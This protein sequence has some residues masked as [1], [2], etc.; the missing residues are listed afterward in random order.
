MTR[1]LWLLLCVAVISSCKET[2]TK[3][4]LNNTKPIAEVFTEFYEF[5]KS[6]NPIEATKAG[7]SAYN[8]TI[9]NYIS[10]DYILHLKDR[11]SYFL[12]AL[13]AYDSAQVSSADYM[14]MR[15]MEW[16]CKVKL[17]GIMNP[18]VTVASPI[19]DLPSFELMPLFQIQSLH[20]YVAQLGGGTSVQP[21]KSIEDYNN[22]LKRLEDYLTFLDTS[23][24]KMRVGM[25]KGIVL[26]KELTLKMLPQV[27]SFIDIPLEENLFYQPIINFPDG[28]SDVD[29]DILKSNYEDFIQNNLTP[30]YVE[31]NE[32]LTEEYLPASRDTD[33]LLDLPNG[34]DTY[35]YLIKLHTTTNMTAD[36][37]HELGLAE[38]ARISKEME[39][40]KNEIGFKGDLKSFFSSLRNKKELMPFSNPE[41]VIESFNAINKRIALRIDSLFALTPKAGFNVRRTEAFREASASAEYVPGSKDGSRAGIFYVP[42]P[43]VKSYNMVHDEALFLHEAIPGHH[44][45][46]SLQQE[47][48]NLPEFLHPESMGV[49]VEGWALYAESLGK[50]LGIYTDPYQYFGMLS[51]EMHRAIRLVVDTGIHAKGWSR[52]KAIQY[53]LDNEAESEE[54]I[55]A[56]IERYMATPGQA[57][58]YKIG[59]LKI[60]ELR[61][62][63]ENALG[64]D[65]NIRKFHSQILDSGSLPLVLLE[66]K[67]DNWILEQDK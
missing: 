22:W 1:T 27:Q 43:N 36:E 33:G 48:T 15:V 52:E 20:L 37:I 14:S 44:F 21:F 65:F 29:M 60:R 28:L 9:A 23:I 26:P 49:F 13:S 66:E 31:L 4:Q 67:I 56:E 7:F 55:I 16:D 61:T 24:E 3:E 40:V 64:D 6:I 46:L 38:V 47:N 39:A 41:E 59:Q 32:F 42:I 57:L 5:K 8:D 35:Q 50:E 62:R 12:E 51:M 34:K 17:E 30:K 58:S 45:Q 11:Y 19:Y 54:S 25:E 2:T 18:I 10:D 63:A 53:S